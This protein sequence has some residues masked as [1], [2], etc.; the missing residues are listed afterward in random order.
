MGFLEGR[1]A[2]VTGAARGLGRE[3]ALLFAAEGAKVVVNDRP[4]SAG[5]AGEVVDEIKSRGGEAVVSTEDVSDWSEGERLVRT[6]VETFGDLHVLVNNAGI[7]RDR[8]IVNM[9]EEEWD[10]V[11]GIDLK[12]H[13]VPLRHAAAYWRERS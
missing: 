2:I 13:F 7:L 10:S 12:G 5:P 9:T 8:S 4:D 1:V 3:H 6:A 11:L